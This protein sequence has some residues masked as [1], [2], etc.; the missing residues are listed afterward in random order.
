MKE[1]AFCISSPWFMLR[2]LAV[3]RLGYVDVYSLVYTLEQV[4]LVIQ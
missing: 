1:F 3:S 2:G 4:G